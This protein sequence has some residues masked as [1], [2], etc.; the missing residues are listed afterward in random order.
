VGPL[1]GQL[2][3]FLKGTYETSEA[4]ICVLDLETTLNSSTLRLA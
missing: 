2:G 4:V 3:G 1:Q